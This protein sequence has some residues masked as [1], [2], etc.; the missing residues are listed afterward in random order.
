MTTNG[1]LISAIIPVYNGEKYLR[2]AVE[3]ILHQG[4][5]ALEIIVVDDGS[6]D[7]SYEL[8]LSLPSTRCF[9]QANLGCAAARNDGVRAAHGEVL[10]FL[11]AD[12]LWVTD[13]IRTQMNAMQDHPDRQL[14]A[15][16]VEEFHDGTVSSESARSRRNNGQ[17][18]YTIGALM[19]NKRDFVRVGFLNESLRFGEFMDWRS[20]ALS[21]GLEEWVLP[22]VV[23]R[24]RLHDHYTTR[25]AN[26]ARRGYLRAIRE[27]LN[28]KR[29]DP[30]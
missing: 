24:R 16:F 22:S 25:C 8:A 15:G 20:R 1:K 4:Y 30:Q 6:S 3:S 18:A 13:K 27:H 26:V 11:D 29:T 12:D 17:R 19:I 7:N 23:L 9:R 5:E 2:A 28:R 10:T 14:V 21:A